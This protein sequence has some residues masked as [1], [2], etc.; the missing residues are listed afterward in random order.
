MTDKNWTP[1]QSFASRVIVREIE[2]ETEKDTEREREKKT[3]D[4]MEK[5][6]EMGRTYW[7]RELSNAL[8]QVLVGEPVPCHQ[9]PQNWNH[10]K[11]V[12]IVEP[13][14]GAKEECGVSVRVVWGGYV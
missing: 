11:R 14:R 2:T 1:C 7:S 12:A 6:T 10:F 4:R 13:A 5:E 3:I 8:H 9:L